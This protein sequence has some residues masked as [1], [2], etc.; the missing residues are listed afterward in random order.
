MDAYHEVSHHADQEANK[1]KKA[2][3]LRRWRKLIKGAMVR[4]RL[5]DEYGGDGLGGEEEDD[6]DS[7]VPEDDEDDDDNADINNRAQGLG[8]EGGSNSVAGNQNVQEEVEDGEGGGFM[9][10]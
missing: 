8:A 10:D 6:K 3:V 5:M 1:R 4:A 7:W 2:E 9:V